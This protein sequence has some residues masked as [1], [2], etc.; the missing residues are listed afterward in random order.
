MEADIAAVEIRINDASYP[1][2]DTN[3][4]K[5]PDNSDDIE[6]RT[7]I[8]RLRRRLKWYFYEAFK[9]KTGTCY[10]H[11]LP[12][13]FF[14]MHLVKVGL[15]TSQMFNF[16]NDR[17]NFSNVVS[18]GH[19]ALRHLFLKGW[20]ATWETLPYPPAHGDFAVYTIDDLVAGINFAVQRYYNVEKDSIGFYERLPTDKLEIKIMYFEFPGFSETEAS[21]G[22]AIR[23]RVIAVNASLSET[24]DQQT[25]DKTYT[26]D[27]LKG[28]NQSNITKP[29][30]KLLATY[31]NFQIHS[32]RVLEAT[33]KAQCL[34]IKGKVMFTDLDN[35]GQVNVEL[36]TLTTRIRCSEMNYSLP[37]PVLENTSQSTAAAVVALSVL[38]LLAACYNISWGVVA[39]YQTKSFMVRYYKKLF[40]PINKDETDLPRSEYLRFLKIWEI[41]ILGADVM[42]IIGSAALFEIENKNFELSTLDSYAVV[43]GI[44]CLLTWFT[45]LRFFKFHNKFHLLF[46][47]IYKA[48]GNVVAYMMCVA[49]LFVGFWI[50]GYVVIGPYHVKEYYKQSPKD[51]DLGPVEKTLRKF[52]TT[53][54]QERSSLRD[55]IYDLMKDSDNRSTEEKAFRTELL[56]IVRVDRTPDRVRILMPR[57]L[58]AFMEMEEDGKGVVNC[59]CLKCEIAFIWWRNN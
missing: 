57:T 47:T 38:S 41:L 5:V 1:I 10:F 36:E 56:K 32:V 51:R 12:L 8:T 53:E 39:F 23:E 15:I 34:R 42:N 24:L 58:K 48:F 7:Q 19:L 21:S 44:G 35:N 18:R 17:A 50:C 9:F 59:R 27:I 43:L 25:G 40:M 33:S 31:I 54:D 20:D 26:C 16:G 13:F 29:I 6:Y 14:L 37:E 2:N 11:L 22:I 30:K 28:F 46:N 52:L 55:S 45:L 3:D 4:N 49:I